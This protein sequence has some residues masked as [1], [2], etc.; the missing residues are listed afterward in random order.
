[1]AAAAE[2]KLAGVIEK[3]KDARPVELDRTKSPQASLA[4]DAAEKTSRP[5]DNKGALKPAKKNRKAK[6]SND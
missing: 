3:F 1:V 6:T 2:R 4:R 5:Q